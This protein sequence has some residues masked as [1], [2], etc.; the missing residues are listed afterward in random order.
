MVHIEHV[1]YR[2]YRT[3]YIS[4]CPA[5]FSRHR[6]NSAQKMMIIQRMKTLG[7]EEEQEAEEEVVEEEVD[8][9]QEEEGEIVSIRSSMSSRRRISEGQG[10]RP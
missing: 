3:C 2:P 1:L 10:R 6:A 9:E 8:V 7:V 4:N 5:G